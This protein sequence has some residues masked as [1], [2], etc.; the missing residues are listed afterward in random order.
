MFE[1]LG[2]LKSATIFSS[3]DLNQGYYQVSIAKD[4]IPKTGFQI[5]NRTFVFH[6]MP[7]GLCNAPAKFQRI[8]NE[9]LK[10]VRNILIYL[11]DILVYSDNLDDNLNTLKEIFTMFETNNVSLNFEKCI[12]A[13]EEI[14]F[15]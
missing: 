2:K 9:M 14:K 5:L 12:F 1:L 7:F 10:D 15:L 4:D 3:L 13:V 11:D 6:K 8:M